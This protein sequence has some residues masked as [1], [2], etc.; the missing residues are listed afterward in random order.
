MLTGFAREE[1]D[2]N[3]WTDIITKRRAMHRR[4]W[5]DN[6]QVAKP[7]AKA[8]KSPP[9]HRKLNKSTST[10]FCTSTQVLKGVKALLKY[11]LA[12]K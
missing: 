12:R 7:K 8:M 2:N 11:Q 3:S 10:S 5:T 4:W 1:E 9:S 6:N